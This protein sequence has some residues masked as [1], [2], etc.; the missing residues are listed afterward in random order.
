[1]A[2]S[3]SIYPLKMVIFM[4]F[5]IAKS[6]FQRVRCGSMRF[7]EAIPENYKAASSTE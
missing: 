6:N 1:M 3:A 7:V 5:A 4:L 2:F